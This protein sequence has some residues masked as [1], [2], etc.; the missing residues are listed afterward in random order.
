ML[1]HDELHA[2]LLPIS[3]RTALFFVCLLRYDYMID[4]PNISLK[5]FIY[6]IVKDKIPYFIISSLYAI[7]LYKLEPKR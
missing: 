6:F 2:Q 5:F 4:F 3:E 1:F 7:Q